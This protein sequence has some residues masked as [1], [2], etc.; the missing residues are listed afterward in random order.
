[1]RLGLS[2]PDQLRDSLEVTVSR[3]E[4]EVVFEDQ[5]R[6]KDRCPEQARRLA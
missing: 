4:N 6:S 2:V 5:L 1:M 3:D